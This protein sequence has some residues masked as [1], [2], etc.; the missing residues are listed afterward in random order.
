M[1]SRRQNVLWISITRT[2][3][4]WTKFRRS[5]LADTRV[6][7]WVG[8]SG[9]TCRTRGKWIPGTMEPAQISPN[10][11]RKLIGLD[12]RTTRSR[13]VY[14]PKA[15]SSQSP[16]WTQTTS[17]TSST[18]ACTGKPQQSTWRKTRKCVRPNR[19]WFSRR[20]GSITSRFTRL[21]PTITKLTVA[22][23]ACREQHP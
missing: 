11:W 8:G 9:Q 3:C 21:T 14:L 22:E 4:S 6:F 13:S 15:Q 2:S 16:K 5:R 19:D 23:K 17:S 10:A 20:M 18:W 7:R 1:P 12:V